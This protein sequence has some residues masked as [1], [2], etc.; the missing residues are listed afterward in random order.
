[1]ILDSSVLVAMARNEPEATEFTRL[2]DEAPRTAVST[3]TLLETSLVLRDRAGQEFVDFVIDKVTVVP[4]DVQQLAVARAAHRRYGR[5]SGHPA[6]LNLGDCFSYALAV[7]SGE[8]LLFKGKDFALTD[9]SPAYV[10]D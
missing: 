10:P 9:V 1:L 5:G 6:R 2:L 8:P 4:F 3:A 7:T